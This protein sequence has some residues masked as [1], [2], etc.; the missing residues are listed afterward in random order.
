MTALNFWSMNLLNIQLKFTPSKQ[1]RIHTKLC[2]FST[3]EESSSH[4]SILKSFQ[5]NFWEEKN[6]DASQK[7]LLVSTFCIDRDYLNLDSLIIQLTL[8]TTFIAFFVKGSKKRKSLKKYPNFCE[9]SIYYR[10]HHWHHLLQYHTEQLKNTF[11]KSF[12]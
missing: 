9:W 6:S 2:C 8:Y 12:S 5:W 11:M 1:M 7:N 10:K 3:L 4:N